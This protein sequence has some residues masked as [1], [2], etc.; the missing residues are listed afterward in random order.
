M[1]QIEVIEGH[2][3]AKNRTACNYRVSANSPKYK[4]WAALMER[5]DLWK[6]EE[7]LNTAQLRQ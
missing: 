6:I 7:N 2:C 3:R 5:R 1:R 4:C